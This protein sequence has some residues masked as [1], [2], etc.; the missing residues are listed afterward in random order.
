MATWTSGVP[1]NAA[2]QVLIDMEIAGPLA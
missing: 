1:T 2:Y